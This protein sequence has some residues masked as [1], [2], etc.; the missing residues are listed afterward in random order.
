MRE[1][2]RALTGWRARLERRASATRTS[3]STRAAR[4]PASKTVFG[5][6]GNFNWEDALPHVRASTRCTPSFF[7]RKLW[8]Y[9]I[10]DAAVGRRPPARSSSSTSSAATR[11]GPWCEA[12]L[13][14]PQLYQGP[15][16]VKPPVV[17]NAGPAARAAAR[18]STRDE[19]V[20]LCRRRRPAAVLPARR[21]RLGRRRAGSTP[22]T[23]RGRW[24]MVHRAH[25]RPLRR[26]ARPRRQLRRHRDARAGAARALGFWGNPELTARDARPRCTASPHDLLAA[27]PA[28]ATSR[29]AVP[30]PAARTRCGS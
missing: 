19:W 8:S 9:F 11:C 27:E 12:I 1:L 6:T 29:S 28:P 17:F 20:W 4:T 23:I 24:E 2:A 16:M 10:A 13:L 26:R 14:H 25:R 22:S 30:R 21:G 18:R 15:R 5:Q 3:A 7:V